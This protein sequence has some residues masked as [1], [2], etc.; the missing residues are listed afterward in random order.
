MDCLDTALEPCG[1]TQLMAILIQLS[2]KSV[3]SFTK[4]SK[5]RNPRNP[6]NK[7]P[8]ARNEDKDLGR[9]HVWPR[10]RTPGE[11]PG[12]LPSPEF[13][14]LV[15]SSDHHGRRN[16]LKVAHSGAARLRV[17]NASVLDDI[18]HVHVLIHRS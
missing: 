17:S 9:N 15:P 1:I 12:D 5:E 13:V 16:P 7:V 2:V 4:R 3:A 14:T 18:Y 10:G 8:S 6:S 11:R